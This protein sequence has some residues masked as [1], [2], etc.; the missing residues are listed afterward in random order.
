MKKVTVVVTMLMAFALLASAEPVKITL[1]EGDEG[2]KLYYSHK[3]CWDLSKEEFL[4][5]SATLSGFPNTEEAWKK[6]RAGK[7]IFLA[8]EKA[9]PQVATVLPVPTVPV[10]PAVEEVKP[11]EVVEEVAQPTEE[12]VDESESFGEPEIFEIAQAINELDLPTDNFDPEL[13]QTALGLESELGPPA[14][15]KAPEAPE[16]NHDQ[17]QPISNTAV[18]E[19]QEQFKQGVIERNKIK[20]DSPPPAPTWNHTDDP[21]FSLPFIFNS[22]SYLVGAIMLVVFC[23]VIYI[24]RYVSQPQGDRLRLEKETKNPEET[25]DY[26]SRLQREIDHLKSS[27]EKELAIQTQ[28]LRDETNRLHE[29]EV[30]KLNANLAFTKRLAEET[31]Y[32]FEYPGIVRKA[33][34]QPVDCIVLRICGRHPNGAV[35]YVRVPGI[36]EPVEVREPFLESALRSD[37][38]IEEKD[39]FILPPKVQPIMEETDQDVESLPT[40]HNFLE[41][42]E[43]P[44][45]LATAQ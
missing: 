33:N 39:A 31:F 4:E 30:R 20:S 9:Q 8:T 21:S 6:I 27:F 40:L 5:E 25:A 23:G 28:S 35:K 15:E 32:F 41:N 19:K 12:K 11:V 44:V 16:A 13:L 24:R 34:K 17:G 42:E 37:A 3:E 38:Y 26:Q 18:A 10:V 2:L 7:E 43:A 29:K 1:Q 22:K 14:F 36:K 45:R